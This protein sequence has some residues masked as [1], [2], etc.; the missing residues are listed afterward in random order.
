MPLDT[1]TLNLQALETSAGYQGAY[2]F[3]DAGLHRVADGAFAE[4]SVAT[5]AMALWRALGPL[6]QANTMLLRCDDQ[7][8]IVSQSG[9]LVVRARNTCNMGLV[10]QLLKAQP[11]VTLRNIAE[12]P[13]PKFTGTRAA[14]WAIAARLGRVEASRVFE[15]MV[16]QYEYVLSVHKSGFSIIDE[17]G[18]TER[19]TR[20]VDEA[21]EGGFDIE[22]T[23]GAGTSGEESS[24]HVLADLF[25][26]SAQNAWVFEATGWPI[27][28]P[29][30]T[31]FAQLELGARMMGA[32]KP[33]KA[34][35]I[36]IDLMD[37]DGRISLRGHSTP[38][39]MRFTLLPEGC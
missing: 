34:D 29:K 8:T 38:E 23:L 27:Q 13:L 32:F 5:R 36:S 21:V 20:K 1:T 28:A 30:T 22:Y 37:R 12:C 31:S 9:G 18:G 17:A 10:R 4:D 2:R 33:L 24:K 7:I 25:G 6:T 15:M 39:G 3:S 35:Q 26:D 19:F 16:G 14:L 11:A